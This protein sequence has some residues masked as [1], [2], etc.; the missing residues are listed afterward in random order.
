MN[1]IHP[2]YLDGSSFI[3]Q[4]GYFDIVSKLKDKAGH[5]YMQNGIINGKLTFTLLGREVIIINSLT[6]ENPFV[7]GNINHGDAIMIK[8]AQHITHIPNDT[9]NGMAGTQTFICEV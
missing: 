9:K 6:N 1:T 2:D 7:F 8:K 4:R 5:F 3:I